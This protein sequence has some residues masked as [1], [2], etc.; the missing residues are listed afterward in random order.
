VD[1]NGQSLWSFC[2]VAV[3]LL[4]I[5]S[6]SAVAQEPHVE[7]SGGY[8]LLHV[9]SASSNLPIGWFGSGGG[10]VAL[11][12]F[13]KDWFGLVGEVSGNQ[14]TFN[15]LGFEL[16]LTALSVMGG[17][18]FV[19]HEWNELTPFAQF[20][21]GIA[22]EGVHS[23]ALQINGSMTHFA[24]QPGGGVDVGV[25]SRYAVRAGVNWRLIDFKGRPIW[26]PGSQLQFIAG[27]VW[28]K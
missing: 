25:T 23:E 19:A 5:S 12:K 27:V 10:R 3:L 15:P 2:I 20:V 7:F 18:K 28:K 11:G 26:R 17:A 21:V 16:G 1:A 6:S 22:R 8:S 14:K 9:N 13:R 24:Y 4:A